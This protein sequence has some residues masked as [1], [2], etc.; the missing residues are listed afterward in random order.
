MLHR[1]LGVDEDMANKV[2]ILSILREKILSGAFLE[3]E[4]LAE[5]PTAERLNVSR[6]PIRIAFRAL[7]LEGLL[8]KL[9]G[10]GYQVRSLSYVDISGAVE[11]RGVLEGLAAR[12]AAE[13]GI[14]T[15]LLAELQLCLAEGD[16]LFREQTMDELKL[17][18]Y[19]ALN[20]RFH[21]L[22]VE[23]SQNPSITK[24]LQ[25]NEHLPMASVNAMVFDPAQIQKEFSRLNY[26]HLQH[27]AVVD[28]IVKRQG[29][30]AEAL[31]KEHAQAALTR[32]KDKALAD[33]TKVIRINF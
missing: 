28:A 27:H 18:R 11:V 17:E 16:T 25:I 5:V 26:A 31:M 2:A 19:V 10:R 7:E 8:V 24:A 32:Y 29:A 1:S 33:Y 12:L 15:T 23:G 13:K 3:G 20:S 14:S 6:T 4:R 21:Q 22:I 30:R 9:P